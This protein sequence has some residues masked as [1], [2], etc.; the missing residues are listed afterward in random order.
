MNKEGKISTFQMGLMMYF[1]V[2]GTSTLLVPSI[3]AK[4][5]GRD[6][7]LSPIWSALIGF[8]NLFIAWQLYKI[9]P[10]TTI[11]ES[12]KKILGRVLGAVFNFFFLF[13]L[14]YDMSIIV[15][16]YGEFIHVFLT[17]TPIYILMGSLILVCSF[18]VLSGI[19]VIARCTQIFLPIVILFFLLMVIFIIPE[20]NPENMLPIM[21]NGLK[22]SLKS[23]VFINEWFVEFI[24]ISFLFP[25]LQNKQKAIRWGSVSVLT[26]MLTM[27]IANFVCLFLLGDITKQ[28]N[29]PVYTAASYI[30]V[31]DFA[32]HLDGI[33]MA[34]W[35][36]V[37]FCQLTMWLYALSFG[38]S[39]WL[40]L[41]E[42]RRVVLP[43]GLLIILFSIWIAPHFESLTSTLNTSFVPYTYVMMLFYPMLLLCIAYIRKRPFL[44]QKT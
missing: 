17:Y 28:F 25:F 43:L 38:V 13:R 26:V 15:R 29:F 2:G 30:S 35:I 23:A 33:V 37:G 8:L 40:N 39:Q 5:A 36:L 41:S 42:Y 4:Y 7:W 18:A 24:Y 16:E 31:A 12:T 34:I 21:E 11:I 32:E 14:I 10:K 9:Y 27:V 19:E 3:A 22:P 6:M 44:N 20:L 1:M